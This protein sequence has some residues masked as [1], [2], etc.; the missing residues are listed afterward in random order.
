MCLS[1]YLY[2]APVEETIDGRRREGRTVPHRPTPRKGGQRCV[3]VCV[4]VCGCV[5]V[6]VVV[7]SV[8]KRRTPRS[9]NLN[10]HSIPTFLPSHLVVKVSGYHL[11]WRPMGH[12]H[13]RWLRRPKRK[14][15]RQ[16]SQ[17]GSY[18]SIFGDNVDSSRPAPHPPPPTPS[19]TAERGGDGAPE[20][21]Q[22]LI[23]GHDMC[24]NTHRA[25][26]ARGSNEC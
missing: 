5:C 18:C 26:G 3:C 21:P 17:D 2:N 1:S 8:K 24:V 11:P 19:S 13:P 9:E 23:L 22:R 16:T 15:T 12:S 7:V 25:S 10:T 4:C 20:I 6:C 14:P